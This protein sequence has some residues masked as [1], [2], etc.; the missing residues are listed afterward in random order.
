MRRVACLWVAATVV[1]GGCAADHGRSDGPATPAAGGTEPVALQVAR[2]TGTKHDR[3]TASIRT[4]RATGVDG[5]TIRNYTLSALA[6]HP[7]TACVNNRDGRFPDA[8]AGTR[9]GA[10]LDPARGEGG[11]LGWCR[12]RYRAKVIYFE[13]YACPARGTCHPPPGFP[14][15]TRVVARFTFR[16]R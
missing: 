3:F 10:V 11:P 5:H 16:V 1:I 7:R 6:T 12:G 4:P 8:S 2:R 14:T 9:V 15:R 13:G